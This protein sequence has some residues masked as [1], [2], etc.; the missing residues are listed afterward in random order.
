MA[1]AR[2]G[3]VETW[4]FGSTHPTNTVFQLG[5]ESPSDLLVLVG[6]S[7]SRLAVYRLDLN[8]K[9]LTPLS[10]P[11]DASRG[12][13]YC[14]SFFQDADESLWLCTSHGIWRGGGKAWTR[15]TATDPG[16]TLWPQRI[17][18]TREGQVW[19]TQ[20]EGGRI[21]LQR[22]APGRLEPFAAPDMPSGLVVTHLL[23]DREGDLWVGTKTGLLRLEPKR[24]RVY[25]RRDGMRS[26]DTLAVAK[27][28]EGTIWVGTAEG[29]S[30]MRNGQ[31]TNLPPPEGP[32]TW[33]RVPV[34]LA[35]RGNALWVGWGGSRL[36]GF[37]EGQW[38]WLHTPAALGN[39]DYLKAMYE[40]RTAR[41]W[42][43]NG[44]RV[45]CNDGGRWSSFSTNNGLSHA[46]VRV[47]YQD[48]RGDLWFGTFGGGLNRLKDGRFTSYKTDRGEPNNRAWW[49]HE[50]ADGLF[51]VGSED[52][53]NRFVPP[54]VPSPGLPATLSPSDGERVGTR[55]RFFRFTTEQGLGENVVNNVQEDEFGYLWL[56]G[57]R[58][59]YRISRQQL[60]EVAA[61][62]RRAVECAA[63]GEA[64]GMLNSE[65][66]GG[67]NQRR[68]QR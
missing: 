47:I 8:T 22:L 24:I 10:A 36:A 13:P 45:L 12:Q 16:A 46:D 49:I 40:D 21:S 56:S 42:L 18:R 59:I 61:G 15:M 5:E 4:E 34:F 32:G 19:V 30:G 64:D 17:Y 55:G 54:G 26:D 51:W 11:A 27:G 14:F 39:M 23:E 50:D 1:L 43:A 44:E 66:N 29:V 35:G 9:S 20:F 65:C 63:Y 6:R 33:K 57:L 53:L 7:G 62:R 37:R 41:T 38:T 31:V 3:R 58:G 2:G 68:L 25:S 28:A 60:N 48:R 67:D 52:G